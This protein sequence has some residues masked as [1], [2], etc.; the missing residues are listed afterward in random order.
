MKNTV[1]E[2]NLF[3]KPT[4]CRCYV[5]E[6]DTQVKIGCPNP[7]PYFGVENRLGTLAAEPLGKWSAK[8][9]IAQNVIIL[10]FSCPFISFIINAGI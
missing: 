7:S 5:P 10:Y 3:L 6:N 1:Y 9:E 8:T 4:K 2:V